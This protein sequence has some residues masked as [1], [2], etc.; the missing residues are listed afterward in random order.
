MNS[1]VM[2]GYAKMASIKQSKNSG[3]YELNLFGELGKVFK[4][5]KL[6][7]FDKTSADSKYIIDGA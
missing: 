3:S 5:M 2:V 7:T 6:I 1:I 4:E